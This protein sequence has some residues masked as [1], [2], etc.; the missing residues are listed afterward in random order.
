MRRR[1][2]TWLMVA[3]TVAS[4]PAAAADFDGTVPLI[5]A[6][7]DLQ[8]CVP[9]ERCRREQAADI[10]LP[11]ILRVDVAAKTIAGE[12]PDGG[13]LRQTPIG[14]VNTNN[15]GLVLQGVDGDRSWN[16]VIDPQGELSIAAIGPDAGF[17][18]FGNCVVR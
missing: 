13:G 8:A 4:V 9:G 2:S 16:A 14:S 18:I 1:F 6:L 7:V 3:A 15:Q 11:N 10:N 17:V 12:P 5:C